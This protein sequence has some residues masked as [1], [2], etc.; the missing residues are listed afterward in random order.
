VNESFAEFALA[1][2]VALE[3]GTVVTSFTGAESTGAELVE[4][5][6]ELQPTTQLRQKPTV[7]NLIVFRK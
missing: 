1:S 4:V 3:P 6:L 2:V 5:E 7:K